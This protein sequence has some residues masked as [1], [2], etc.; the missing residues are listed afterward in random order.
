MWVSSV[1]LVFN[2]ND[3]S[4]HH[5]LSSYF[6][7]Q[8]GESLLSPGLAVPK[9]GCMLDS[10]K[11]YYMFW[12]PGT[13]RPVESEVLEVGSMHW[14]FLRLP[15]DSITHPSLR[16]SALFDLRSTLKGVLHPSLFPS[17]FHIF[18]L[19]P[20]LLLLAFYLS[21]F[22][23]LSNWANISLYL[24]IFSSDHASWLLL[25][26]VKCVEDSLYHLFILPPSFC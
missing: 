16:T 13:P 9:L 24:A 15:S 6:Q 11:K 7:I 2:S 8:R 20:P 21:K 26:A 18:S 19:L 17:P 23:G 1:K 5:F 22:I 3:L 25:F 12:C 10:I 14:L 4:L